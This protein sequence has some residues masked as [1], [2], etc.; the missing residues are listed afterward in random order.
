MRGK[1]A[2]FF[3]G[4]GKLRI[5]P[6]YAGKSFF[7]HQPR[8]QV[9]DHPRLCGEKVTNGGGVVY[10]LGSPPPMRGKAE[11]NVTPNRLLGDHPR[12]CGEK[13]VRAAG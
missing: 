8:H 13:C 2:D 10:Q 4:A 7:H 9:P 6:A 5:T 12:L 3:H 11:L 1:V